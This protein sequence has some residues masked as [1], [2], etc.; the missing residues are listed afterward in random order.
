MLA[1]LAFLR[2]A[3]T[4]PTVCLSGV[5]WGSPERGAAAICEPNPPRPFARRKKKNSEGIVTRRISCSRVF[6]WR[7]ELGIKLFL[8]LPL[9]QMQ[10]GI[11]RV[12]TTFTCGWVG[13]YL[14]ASWRMIVCSRCGCFSKQ[15]SYPLH[16]PEQRIMNYRSTRNHCI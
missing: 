14:V 13:M 11:I 7:S 1:G 12:T 15:S 2:D 10:S 6:L 8:H 5:L 4:V 3:V 16:N 9:L